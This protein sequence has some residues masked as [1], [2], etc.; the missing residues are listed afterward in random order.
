[1]DTAIPNNPY[2]VPLER[3]IRWL[4]ASIEILRRFGHDVEYEEGVLNRL[5]IEAGRP[6]LI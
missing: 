6:T 2:D 3:R 4:E 1:M 5:L